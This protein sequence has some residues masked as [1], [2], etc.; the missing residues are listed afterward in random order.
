LEGRDKGEVLVLGH[1]HPSVLLR[2]KIGATVRL[3]C[4]LYHTVERILILPAFSRITGGSNVMSR[5][6]LSR[7]LRDIEPGE[8]QAYA[9]SEIGLMELG[10]LGNL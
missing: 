8:F 9:V 4:F 10:V 5:G 1:E 7:A 6:F 2:D 3:P